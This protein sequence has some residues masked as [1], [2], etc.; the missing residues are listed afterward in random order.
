VLVDEVVE[1]TSVAPPPPAPLVT[2]APLVALTV[3]EVGVPAVVVPMV[4]L[5]VTALATVAVVVLLADEVVVMPA[6]TEV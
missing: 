1:V 5:D 2:V 3:P 6:P 4:V